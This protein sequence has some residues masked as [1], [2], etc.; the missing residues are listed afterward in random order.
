MIN[1]VPGPTLSFFLSWILK[2]TLMKITLVIRLSSINIVFIIIIITNTN[3]PVWDMDMC[4]CLDS[5]PLPE[6][7]PRS[8]SLA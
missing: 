1:T 6:G 2:Q 3:I 8:R 4:V 7:A 5:L